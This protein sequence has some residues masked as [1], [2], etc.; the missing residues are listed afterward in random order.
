[1]CETF[2]LCLQLNRVYVIF[3]QPTTISMIK[4]WNYSKTVNRGAKDFAVSLWREPLD[5]KLSTS[6]RLAEDKITFR[7]VNKVVFDKSKADKNKAFIKS[8]LSY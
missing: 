3:D 2:P 4:I 6:R 5:V 8:H 1:M 7:H